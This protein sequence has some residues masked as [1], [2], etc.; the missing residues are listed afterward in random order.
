[1]ADNLI[2]YG[3]TAGFREDS[4]FI[5]AVR[6]ARAKPMELAIA[7]R[8]HTLCWAAQSCLGLDGDYVEC[9]TDEG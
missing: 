9:G 8:T 1:M 4:R 3:H 6:G 7:W 5:S 2:T